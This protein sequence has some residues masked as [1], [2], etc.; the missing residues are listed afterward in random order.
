[1]VYSLI[2]KSNIVINKTV[3]KTLRTDY[4][5]PYDLIIE[6]VNKNVMIGSIY[7]P[8]TGEFS[9]VGE[10]YPEFEEPLSE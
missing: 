5:F 8:I 7:D 1:M 9:V 4:P 10:P 2:I 3:G 6:D